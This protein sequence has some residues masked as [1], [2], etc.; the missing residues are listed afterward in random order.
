M[1]RLLIID[2]HR[3]SANMLAVLLK[4]RNAEADVQV[5]FDGASGLAL[6]L[7]GRHD[8]VVLD[9]GL[10]D[11][12][13]AEVALRIRRRPDGAV[14]LLVALSG[15]VDEVAR[16]RR[17]GLFDHALLKPVDVERLTAILFRHG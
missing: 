16:H 15:S 14:P 7:A 11:I 1:R 17:S 8:A 9:L 2:D 6:A 13:G 4:L 10:P 3:D 12:D 5:A